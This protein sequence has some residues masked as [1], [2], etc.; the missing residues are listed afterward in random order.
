MLKSMLIV[1]SVNATCAAEFIVQAQDN[2]DADV[3]QARVCEPRRECRGVAVRCSDYAPVQ[4][5]RQGRTVT[6]HRSERCID[7]YRV[8]HRYDSRLHRPRMSYDP[9]TRNRVDLPGN[10]VFRQGAVN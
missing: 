9:G 2:Q 1:G 6:V 3:G 8:T 4:H 5:E 7:A 10:P